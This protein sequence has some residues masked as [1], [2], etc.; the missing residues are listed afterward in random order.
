M[1]AQR[2]YTSE[3]DPWDVRW[4]YFMAGLQ[5]Y[6]I[7]R[8]FHKSQLWSIRRRR[9]SRKRTKRCYMRR[10]PIGCSSLRVHANVFLVSGIRGAGIGI[11]GQ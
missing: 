11:I 4:F 9:P 8:G 7:E 2:Y 5:N 6:F 1:Q 3:D 10:R